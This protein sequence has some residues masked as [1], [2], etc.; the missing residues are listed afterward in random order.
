MVAML[1][2]VVELYAPL[3]VRARR[4]KLAQQNQWARQRE[5]GFQDESRIP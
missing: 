1:P 3:K 4:N 2:G 5:M